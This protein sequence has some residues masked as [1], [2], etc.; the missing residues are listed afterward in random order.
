MSSAE[1]ALV[2]FLT[3]VFLASSPLQAGGGMYIH[4]RTV[5]TF[6]FLLT[7]L[8]RVPG[9]ARAARQSLGSPVCNPR[10]SPPESLP[11]YENGLPFQNW[12]IAGGPGATRNHHRLLHLLD[13]LMH[14]TMS[15]R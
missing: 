13:C 15:D 14:T 7:L 12:G 9:W 5:P 4:V 8:Q 2:Y 3:A 6:H 1:L 10:S 11:G